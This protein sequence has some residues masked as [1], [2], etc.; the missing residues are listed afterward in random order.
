MDENLDLTGLGTLISNIED[1]LFPLKTKYVGNSKQVRDNINA[2]NFKQFIADKLFAK[3]YEIVVYIPPKSEHAIVEKTKVVLNN[4]IGSLNNKYGNKT[5]IFATVVNGQDYLVD[6]KLPVVN[7]RIK[8]GLLIVYDF[9]GA[10]PVR[11]DQIKIF[12]K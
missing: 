5:N 11:L 7:A 8:K 9:K 3:Q 1:E 4:D 2:L 12:K 6:K 10:Q